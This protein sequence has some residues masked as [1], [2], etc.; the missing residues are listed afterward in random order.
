MKIKFSF[1][2]SK[3]R[4]LIPDLIALKA[5]FYGFEKPLEGLSDRV[6][7]FVLVIVLY[8]ALSILANVIAILIEATRS[9]FKKIVEKRKLRLRSW[10]NE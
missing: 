9:E 2:P 5:F 4:N 8:F 3:A 10:N 6:E 7:Y 1:I